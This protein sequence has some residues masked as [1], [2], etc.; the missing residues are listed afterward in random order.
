MLG[1]EVFVDE[2]GELLPRMATTPPTSAPPATAAPIK[3][4]LRRW[5]RG[6]SLVAADAASDATGRISSGSAVSAMVSC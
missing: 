5:E 2:L 1:C 6:F 4:F 3:I